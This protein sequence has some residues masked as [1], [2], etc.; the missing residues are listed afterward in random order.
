M[1]DKKS[2]AILCAGGPAPGMNTVVGTVAKR[3][4]N[5]GY[6]VLGLNYGYKTIFTDKPNYT[7]FDYLTA[8]MIVDRGGSYL[9]MSRHKPKD[10]EFTT[11]FF[12]KENVALLVTIGGDDTAST[13]NRISNYL[14]DNNIQIQNIHVPKTI[15]NDLPLPNNIST[16]GYQ[17]AKNE[18]V[19]IATTIYEDAKTSDGWFVISAMGREAGH[20]AL[21]IG[22]SCHYPMIIIPEM[23]KNVDITFDRI[24]KMIISAQVKRRLM[25]LDYGVAVISEGVFHF[26]TD[27]EILNSGI[28]FTFDD[29]GHPELGNVSKA[30]IFNILLQKELKKLG[31]NFRSRPDEIGYEIRCCDPIAFDLKYCTALGNGVKELYERGEKGCIVV[32]TQEG[33]IQPLYLKDI[34]GED[35]KV[36]PRLVDVNT[37]EF[38]L[39][40]NS[41]EFIE[42]ADVKAAKAYLEHPEDY[43]VRTILKT[44]F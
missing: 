3:F 44:D 29:H 1:P 32:V 13:A 15:D 6:R 40:F 4:L 9:K 16:F 31:L 36:K 34:S 35:G 24:I 38:R 30:H 10:K 18:G 2:I 23:F 42:D 28:E 17:T 19:R 20:L 43:N 12:E 5:D 14:A 11:T 25:G 22:V 7:E 39:I 33:K 21:G 27:N 37:E 26:M 8:D 41:M